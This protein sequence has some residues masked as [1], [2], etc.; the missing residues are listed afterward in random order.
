METIQY[1]IYS[2]KARNHVSGRKHVDVIVPCVQEP[3]PPEVEDA[4]ARIVAAVPGLSAE[5]R[6]V[7]IGAG[8]GCL[9]RH[10]RDAG[11]QD[12]LAVDLSRR[13]LDALQQRVG[14][15]STLGNDLGVRLWCGDVTDLPDYALQGTDAVFFNACFGNLHDQRAALLRVALLLRPGSRVVLSHPLGRR[16]VEDLRSSDPAIVP[17]PLPTRPSLEALL[18]DLPLHIES[19]VDDA[20]FYLAVL[21]VPRLYRV[22]HCSVHPR[23]AP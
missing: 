21:A 4:L 11:V 8:T 2:G 18:R 1:S 10:L 16:F 5:S 7:D 13:M 15:P 14:E 22:R 12:I 3:Q 23:A 20:S 6:V 17:H 19:F 9:V